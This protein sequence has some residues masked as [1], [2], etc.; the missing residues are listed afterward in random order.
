MKSSPRRVVR[1]IA[2]A[3]LEIEDAER[4][5]ALEEEVTAFVA[6]AAFATR[7]TLAL[8]LACLRFAPL[9]LFVSWRPLERLDRDRRR[10]VLERVERSFFGLVL[11]PWRT[12]LLLHFYEDTRELARIGYRSERKRHLAVIPVPAT[13]G[14]RLKDASGELE[15]DDEK[16]AA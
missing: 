14:V 8:A 10:D 11:V 5:R 15:Q 2:D 7:T 6:A 1:A 12:L 16:G 4:I 13:S 3:L 9:L